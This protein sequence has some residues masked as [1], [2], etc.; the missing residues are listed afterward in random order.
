MS[1]RI[2]LLFVLG[3]FAV[4]ALLYTG[5]AHFF[6]WA[7]R[8]PWRAMS[9]P[10]KVQAAQPAAAHRRREMLL[11]LCTLALF[12]SFSALI[13]LVQPLG[14]TRLYFQVQERGWPY[15]FASIGLMLALHDLY[16]YG[17][18]RLLHRPFMM[19]HV[20]AW[21]HRSTNPT[22]WT[23]LSFH[24]IEALFEGAIVPLSVVVLPMHPAALAIWFVLMLGF[25]LEGH[26][27]YELRAAR[28]R[29]P[30]SLL[31]GSSFHNLHHQNSRHNLGLYTGVWD[32]LFHTAAP[33]KKLN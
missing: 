8:G 11:S 29:W 15:F 16:F 20:H 2:L 26:C 6:E 9:T 28:W 22:V 17:M 10:R 4:R 13:L 31:A 24:P 27:G 7:V 14:W 19:R 3:G 32:W 18:H 23:A 5:V 25:N 33:A 12:S 30:R 21:H 1:A